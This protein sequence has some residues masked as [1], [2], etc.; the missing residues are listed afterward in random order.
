ME[1]EEFSDEIILVGVDYIGGEDLK[2]ELEVLID[3][4]RPTSIGLALCEKR[5]ESLEEK[6]EWLKKPLLSSYKG[7]ESSTLMYQM[8]VDAVRENLRNF[9]KVEPEAHIAE[10]VDVADFLD[11][12]VK[13][14]D[15]DITVT[16]KRAVRDMSPIETL[17]VGWYF[18]SAML[19]F[20]DEKKERS[21]DEM[22][23]HDDMVEGVIST[24]DKFSPDIAEKARWERL[25]YMSRKVY[26]LSKGGK[27]LAIIPRSKID[28]LKKKLGGLTRE[29]ERKG[30]VSGHAHLEE[31]GKK[32]YKKLL[33]YASP[34]FFI[35]LAIYL[36]LFSDVLSIWRAWL[37]WFIAVGG[38]AS[39]GA[40][41]G[42]GHGLSI[43][44]SFL[45]APFM[46]LTLI[47]PGWIAGYVE[48]R[49]RQPTIKDVQD[50]M[51]SAS[52]NDFLSN[53]LIRPIMVGIFANIFTWIGL[54]VVL[55]LLITLV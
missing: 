16:L 18:K 17:K 2:E 37:Y 13:F 32:L 31:V 50:L 24:L 29:E 3:N 28:D 7:G 4:Y 21:V 22:E 53:N 42:R 44:I 47:G 40:L 1:V 27:M 36:F 8:F 41:I 35:S 5:F 9:K 34:I 38:M 25:E 46:S 54:F 43:L 10:L 45:L 20:S 51:S 6:E 52:L 49:V 30:E 15:R 14:I 11:V 39:F 55:P 19:S 48:A 33:R 12:D 26:Q 23:K